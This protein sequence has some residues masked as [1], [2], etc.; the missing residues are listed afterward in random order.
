MAARGGFGPNLP[1]S[2]IPITAHTYSMSPAVTLERNPTIK[3]EPTTRSL[4]ISRS[5]ELPR[6]PVPQREGAQYA[7]FRKGS[8][9]EYATTK[10]AKDAS[11]SWFSKVFGRRRNDEVAEDTK[12]YP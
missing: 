2:P 7:R 12:E 4:D 6:M 11:D 1:I 9:R 8:P 3:F 10:S 5:I